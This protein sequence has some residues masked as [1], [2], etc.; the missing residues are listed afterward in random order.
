MA[1]SALSKVVYNASDKGS[2]NYGVGNGWRTNY[3]Q[4]VY[5]EGTDYYVW[6]DADGTRHYFKKNASDGIYYDEDKLNLKLSVSGST[7]T[8]TDLAGNTSTFDANGRLTKLQNNQATKSSINIT[9]T[10]TTGYLISQ[11][12]D[13]VNRVY[14]FTY[15]SGKLTR[16]N[17]KATGTTELHYVTLSYNSS[18]NLTGITDRDGKSCAYTY[19]NK[20]LTK[21]SDPQG[22]GLSFAYFSTAENGANRISKITEI[23]DSVSGNFIQFSYGNKRTTLTDKQGN[24]QHMLF[25]T[26]GN[27]IT[28]QDDK[29]AA[30]VAKY[31]TD[32]GAGGQ[33]HELSLSS[34]LR[35]PVLSSAAPW[36]ANSFLP[37]LTLKTTSAKTKLR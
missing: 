15:T 25:N 2:N 7:K 14:A 4:R 17:Y 8:I 19:S 22:I 27:T 36:F 9:Y 12:T 37:T 35:S 1:S 3:H 21:A 20:L 16:I 31:A 26:H 30:V 34:D 28:V 10:T 6:E 29:G 11:I 33:K 13:G 23:D 18:N 5:G 32:E 24:V